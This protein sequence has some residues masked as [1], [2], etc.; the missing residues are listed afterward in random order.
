[1]L[2]A[3]LPTGGPLCGRHCCPSGRTGAA[4]ALA[5][6]VVPAGNYGCWRLPPCGWPPLQAALATCIHPYG[7]PGRS[8]PCLAVGMVMAGRPS[9]FRLL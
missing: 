5:T 6:T 9:S 7:A 8:R 3:A 1:M 2:A 4:A